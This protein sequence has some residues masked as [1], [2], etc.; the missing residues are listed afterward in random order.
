[1]TIEATIQ[2]PVQVE[3]TPKITYEEFLARADEDAH[4]EWVNGEVIVQMTAKPL[5]Q[6]VLNFLN[7]LL[8]TFVRF[9]GLGKVFTAPMQMKATPQG[10]GREPDLLFVARAHLDRV[11]ETHLDGPADLVV[12]IVSD[13][14]VSRDLDEKFVEYQEAG[15]AEYWIIDPRPRRKRAWFY[16]LDERGQYQPVPLTPDGVYRSTV[17]PGFWLNVNWLW[18]DELPDPLTTFAEIVGFS[19]EMKNALRALK[20]QA[21]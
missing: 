18:G 11:L 5:H 12:E 21:R 10:P 19:D 14:S 1:M 9:F 16:R 4:V 6:D 2:A 7:H 15:I 20:E 8:D 13:E 3:S 17:V